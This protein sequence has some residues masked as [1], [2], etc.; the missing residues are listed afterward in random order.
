[1]TAER[2]G[3]PAPEE[4]LELVFALCHEIG[5]LVAAIRLEAHLL[6]HEA[7]ELSL[8]R[9]AIS[10]EDLS[11][12]VGA[13]LTQVRP[14]LQPLPQSEIGRVSPG[15]LLANLRD[16]FGERGAGGLSIEIEQEPDLPD[17]IGD[18]ERTNALLWLVALGALEAAEANS[19]SVSIVARQFDEHIEILVRDDGEADP[20][21]GEWRTAAQ[22]GRSLVCQVA[23]AL[24]QPLGGFVEVNVAESETLVGLRLARADSV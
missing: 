23:Q 9:S 7:S 13:L 20:E 18:P 15:A 24:L 11:S 16:G 22:R 17:V 12:R 8:A 19:G 2:G 6:D 5:N 3:S 4:Y 10:I 1:M 14:L 21:L